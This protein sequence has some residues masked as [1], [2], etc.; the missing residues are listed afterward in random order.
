MAISRTRAQIFPLK[1]EE[2]V[3]KRGMIE[4]VEVGTG[5]KEA[6]LAILVAKV[7][8]MIP[9]VNQAVEKIRME[10]RGQ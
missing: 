9:L 4:K 10:E 5:N 1:K 7:N 3:K 6:L 8:E 2:G